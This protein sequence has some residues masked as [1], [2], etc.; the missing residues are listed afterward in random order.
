MPVE[1]MNA[2]FTGISKILAVI[3]LFKMGLMPIFE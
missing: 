1:P 2:G 3:L